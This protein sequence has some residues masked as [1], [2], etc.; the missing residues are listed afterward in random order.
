MSIKSL[1][2]RLRCGYKEMGNLDGIF[3][4]ESL[5]WKRTE[6]ECELHCRNARGP[7]THC[8]NLNIRGDLAMCCVLC[9]WTDQLLL[10]SDDWMPSLT[11][12]SPGVPLSPSLSLYTMSRHSCPLATG[13]RLRPAQWRQARALRESQQLGQCHHSHSQG[14][15][16]EFNNNQ[17]SDFWL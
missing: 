1:F 15:R 12:W 6:K 14:A 2:A 13:P 3:Q 4:P 7:D 16:F 5:G 9:T 17:S 8:L 11:D 10:W